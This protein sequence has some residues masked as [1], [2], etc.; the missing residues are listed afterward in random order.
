MKAFYRIVSP[1]FYRIFAVCA[2]YL[3]YFPPYGPTLGNFQQTGGN[4]L[5]TRWEYS[6]G[7]LVF[8]RLVS[9][10]DIEP[11]RSRSTAGEFNP[12]PLDHSLSRPAP[13]P[14]C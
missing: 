2:S 6:G 13:R 10:V 5:L 12:P 8:N 14:G 9:A 11:S 1:Y 3:P 7:M 4:V